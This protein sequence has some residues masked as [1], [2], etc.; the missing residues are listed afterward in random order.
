MRGGFTLVELLAVISILALL[1][2]IL[3]PALS[4]ARMHGRTVVGISNQRAI[5]RAVSLY[6]MDNDEGYPDSIATIGFGD[7]W[8]W[9]EPMML[10]GYSTRSP[11]ARRS[12]S[13][14]LR[15]YIEKGRVVYCPNAPR[16]Y[17]H[18]EAAWRAGDDWDNPDTAVTKDAVSGTYCFYWNYTGSLGGRGIFMGPS[19]PAGRKGEGTVLLSDYYGYDHWR[20]PGMFGSCERI[21][22]AGVT[23]GTYGSSPYWSKRQSR[24][25][26]SLDGMGIRLHA[27]YVDGHVAEYDSREVVPMEVIVDRATAEPYPPGVG[28]GVI[29]LPEDGTR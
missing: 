10:T 11:R 28:P 29:F 3:A 5:V 27:G 16:K 21:A 1:M 20:S 22:G 17:K 14:Y 4:K 6:A 8:N 23:E 15:R 12:M 26:A 25:R 7:L 24:R 18:L 9:Q 13:G 19:G 2:G